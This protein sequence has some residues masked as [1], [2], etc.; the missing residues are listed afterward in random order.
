ML[1][2]CLK[3]TCLGTFKFLD[4]FMLCK[5]LYTDPELCKQLL[6][7]ILGKEIKKFS[8]FF[9]EKETKGRMAAEIAQ[10]VELAV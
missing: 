3:S 5:M 2:T 9:S 10:K 8:C 4:D 7:L 6:E 1:K